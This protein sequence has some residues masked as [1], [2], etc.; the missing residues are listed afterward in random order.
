MRP[1]PLPYQAVEILFEKLSVRCGHNFLGTWAG[2]DLRPIKEDWRQQL[3]GVTPQ[4]LDYAM[5]NLTPGKPPKDVMEFRRL[6]QSM[7]DERRLNV[8]PPPTGKV[9]IPAHVQ[10]AMDLLAAPRDPAEPP[11][12]VRN[13]QAYIAK[14]DEGGT[15]RQTGMGLSPQQK[16]DLAFFKKILARHDAQQDLEQRKREAQAAVDAY[17]APQG[18]AHADE[19]QSPAQ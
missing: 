14:W 4:Q 19:A 1:D 9:V 7:P 13:A 18:A 16:S 12:R 10:A 6:C 3:A 2:M 8:L 15:A 11:E 5:D 17:H